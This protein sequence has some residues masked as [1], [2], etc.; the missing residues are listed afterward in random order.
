MEVQSH[1]HLLM[2]KEI[3]SEMK[4]KIVVLYFNP[5][6]TRDHA[7]AWIDESKC[8]FSFFSFII[9]VLRWLLRVP[10]EEEQTFTAIIWLCRKLKS[11]PPLN[12]NKLTVCTFFSS[13]KD[14]LILIQMA[15]VI[16]GMLKMKEEEAKL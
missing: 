1:G 5:W 4:I 7:K 14:S 15:W 13:G 10:I 6:T 8:P 3:F 11:I 2:I 12:W 16:G 9:W